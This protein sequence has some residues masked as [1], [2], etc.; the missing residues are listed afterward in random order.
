MRALV[1][2]VRP[3]K[4]REQVLVEDWPEPERPIGNEVKT[5]TIYSGIT[6]GTEHNE[7][8]RGN[9]ASADE[10]LP[11]SM[12]YQIVGRVV[13]AGPDATEL[14]VGDVL[15]MSVPHE[16]FAVK[17]EDSL[18]I[19]LP[20]DVDPQHAAL[21]G[22]ASVAMHTCRNADLRVGE[23]VLVVG[24]GSIGQLASQIA[25]VMGARVTACDVEPRRLELGRDI[26][27]AEEVFD[28]SG[29]G[30]ARHVGDGTY[31]AV[32]DF[33]GIPGMED[34]LITAVRKR[35]RVLPIAGRFNVSY[36]FNLGQG[37]EVTI[38][39]NSHFNRDD[40]ANLCRLVQRGMVR[41]GPLIRDVVSVNEAARI[42]DT[43]RDRPSELL[44]TVFVW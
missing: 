40:L 8:I 5:Q 34:Q 30:W 36:S 41:I 43:L 37:H 24:L 26:G 25:N 39:Q 14:R 29:D 42:Y 16:E 10:R 22:M 33:A 15:Y 9:Y 12:G 44:G 6:N 28:S 31:D 32:I 11:S 21:F 17:P 27:A 23:R 38:K 18:L 3:D 4:Q 20:S 2:R 13:E 35:G 7:L 1:T 19:K